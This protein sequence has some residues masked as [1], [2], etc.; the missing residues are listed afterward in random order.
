MNY[1]EYHIQIAVVRWVKINYPDV[2]FTCAPAVAKSARQGKLNKDMGYRKGWPDLFFAKTKKGY[3]GLFI[4]LKA[5]GGDVAKEQ[6]EVKEKARSEGYS[7]EICFGYEK[8]VKTILEY[9]NLP[10]RK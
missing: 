6:E 5:I 3:A 8:A 4:E 9:M 10:D 2:L 7:A 1:E